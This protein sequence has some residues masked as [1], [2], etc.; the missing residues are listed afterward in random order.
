M[1]SKLF[2]VL[3]R[4]LGC[5]PM[6]GLALFSFVGSHTWEWWVQRG[7]YLHGSY[8]AWRVDLGL[9]G[10][11]GS[12]YFVAGVGVALL[13]IASVSSWKL[14]IAAVSLLVVLLQIPGIVAHTD[15]QWTWLLGNP[16]VFSEQPHVGVVS[17]A[18]AFT[19]VGITSLG[20]AAALDRVGKV[21][22]KGEA[23]QDGIAEIRRS[24]LLLVTAAAVVTLAVSLLVISVSLGLGG[25]I[26]GTSTGYGSM[27]VWTTVAASVLAMALLYSYLHGRW[28]QRGDA[29]A[30]VS[31]PELSAAP[32]RA[33][34]TAFTFMRPPA[35]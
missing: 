12:E 22:H 34:P 17:L 2:V 20:V 7:F 16:N 4:A 26:R 5:S 8:P 32:D 23:D 11:M 6:I 27:L 14:V 33:A 25:I 21:L 28:R 31:R 13:L 30:S 15:F 18:L 24:S 10:S 19:P 9:L 35:A 29:V 3:I 1:N